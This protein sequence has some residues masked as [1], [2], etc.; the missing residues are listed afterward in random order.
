MVPAPASST[1]SATAEASGSGGLPQ[2]DFSLWPGQIVWA[3]IIFAVLYIVLSTMFLPRLR[4]A[5]HKRASAISG[6]LAEAR[7]LRDEA[8]AQAKAAQAE[9]APRSSPRKPRRRP[10]PKPAPARRRPRLT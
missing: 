6:A 8:E 3:L 1:L 10:R 2:F 9:I 7:A 4:H 5:L